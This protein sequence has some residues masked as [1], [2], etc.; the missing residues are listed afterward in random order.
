MLELYPWTSP[1][2]KLLASLFLLKLVWTGS[3]STASEVKRRKKKRHKNSKQNI[4][5][6]LPGAPAWVVWDPRKQSGFQSTSAVVGRGRCTES[7][8]TGLSSLWKPKSHLLLL[9]SCVTSGKSLLRAGAWMQSGKG[10]CQR[11]G[12]KNPRRL[13]T[14]GFRWQPTSQHPNTWLSFI[15]RFCYRTF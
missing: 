6:S 2:N 11:E 13:K 1:Q 4:S 9:K 8:A 10:L 7:G 14:T 5:H 12:S 3:L 15:C